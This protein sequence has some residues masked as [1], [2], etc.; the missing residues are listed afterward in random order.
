MHVRLVDAEKVV[1]RLA[2]RAVYLLL[3][4]N[5]LGFLGAILL[6]QELQHV[7]LTH[8]E[9]GRLCLGIQIGEAALPEH[10][11]R[12]SPKGLSRCFGPILAL[13]VSLS[14]NLLHLLLRQLLEL[15][16]RTR[17]Q[18][19]LVGGHLHGRRHR[20]LGGA[21]G[22]HLSLRHLALRVVA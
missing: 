14:E 9:L 4:H 18:D 16:L 8:F 12:L 5:H 15:A 2:G 1:L 20:Q 3:R 11:L 6:Y 13:R 22:H 17:V 10:C 19:A 7:V 21:L